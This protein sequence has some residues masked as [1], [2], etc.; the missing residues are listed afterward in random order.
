MERVFNSRIFVD[1]VV[2]SSPSVAT[3]HVNLSKKCVREKNVGELGDGG[4][5]VSSSVAGF[6]RRCCIRAFVVRCIIY[7]SEFVQLLYIEIFN[8]GD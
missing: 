4:E 1:D 2:C 7:W 5:D 8:E 3:G 6:V